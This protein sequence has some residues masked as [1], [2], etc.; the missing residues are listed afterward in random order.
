MYESLTKL[1]PHYGEAKAYGEWLSDRNHEGTLDD[2]VQFPF[3][4]YAW[5]VIALEE[6]ASDFVDA[7][8]KLGL[9]RYSDILAASG[10]K[11]DSESM[12]AADVSKLDG[13]TVAALIVG[14]VRADRF[15]EGVLLEFCE[16][17]CMT[18]WLARLKE[19]DE[20][21]SPEDEV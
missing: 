8:P 7:H 14:A 17:G 21:E 13:R 11:W 18:R 4:D 20:S 2:P 5:N 6:A 9:T 16:S 12:S 1:L 19:I 3:V 10:I 15:S